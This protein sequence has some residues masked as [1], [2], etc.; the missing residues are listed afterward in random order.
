MLLA[1]FLVIEL[2]TARPLLPL[3]LF[4]ERDRAAGYANIFFGPMAGMSRYAG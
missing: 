4:L 2:R 3:R 1:A